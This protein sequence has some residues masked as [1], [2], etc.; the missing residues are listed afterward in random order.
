MVNFLINFVRGQHEDHFL[1]FFFDFGP[2]VQEDVSFEDI[3]YLHLELWR[4][5][6]SKETISAILVKDIMRNNSVKLF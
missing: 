6:C 4:P 1:D 5:F 2:L 3:S